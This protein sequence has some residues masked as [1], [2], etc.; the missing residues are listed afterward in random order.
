MAVGAGFDD[1]NVGLLNLYVILAYQSIS[2]H[3]TLSASGSGTTT[4]PQHQPKPKAG[5]RWVLFS[6]II[7]SGELSLSFLPSWISQP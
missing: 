2:G 1:R 5:Q 3:R 4:Q 7:S 6:L